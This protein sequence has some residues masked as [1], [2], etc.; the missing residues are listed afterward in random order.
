[1]LSRIV[2]TMS[3][4][5]AFKNKL[6]AFG[7]SVSLMLLPT[8]KCSCWE[9]GYPDKD[10]ALC[11]GEGYLTSSHVD[12]KAFVLPNEAS[13]KEFTNDIGTAKVG[14]C[15]AFFSPDLDLYDYVKVVWDDVTYT[16]KDRDREMIGS[17]IIYR[18]AKLERVD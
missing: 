8:T 18:V 14:E 12:V 4:A 16:I 1:M 17:E 15:T 5:S 7:S 13:P 6:E 10:C 11:D 2:R 3:R 9:Y